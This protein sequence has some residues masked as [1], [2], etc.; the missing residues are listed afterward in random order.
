MEELSVGNICFNT[1]DLGGHATA[2][3]L[4]KDYCQEVDAICFIVDA[5]DRQ[6]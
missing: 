3:R 6:R 1:Y 4:W 5:H 2:R